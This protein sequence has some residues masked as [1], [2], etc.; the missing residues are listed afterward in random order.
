MSGDCDQ[1][2]TGSAQAA[3]VHEKRRCEQISQEGRRCARWATRGE[4]MCHAHLGY[5]EARASRVV[6]VPLLEDEAS[7]R[8]VISQTTHAVATGAMPPANG[9]AVISGCKLAVRLLEFQL[10][11]RQWEEKQRSAT[12][13]T[14]EMGHPADPMSPTSADM[15]HPDLGQ[16]ADPISP[17]SGDMGHPDLGQPEVGNADL[18]AVSDEKWPFVPAGQRPFD[19]VQ[20]RVD[21]AEAAR[22]AA[23]G[24]RLRLPRFRPEDLKKQWESGLQRPYRRN[25]NNMWPSKE[26]T[27][28]IF[29]WQKEHPEVMRAREQRMLD[30]YFGR[31]KKDGAEQA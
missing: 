29:R 3:E 27:Q 30:E 13:K 8:Y 6:H 10:K 25:E 20:A 22:Y 2:S 18:M 1:V 4:E 7:I 31:V 9:L 19:R 11:Q 17:N 16:P 21:A 28:A 12:P 15:G 5:A 26:E 24:P 14:R 23:E